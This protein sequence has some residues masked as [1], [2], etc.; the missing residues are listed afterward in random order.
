MSSKAA[1]KNNMLAFAHMLAEDSC[2]LPMAIFR[3][4][5]DWGI[6]DRELAPLVRIAAPAFRQG[7]VTLRQ[8]AEEFHCPQDKALEI[9]QYFV[10]R[11]LLEYD[12]QKDGYT[13]DKLIGMI[14]E[15]WL[16]CR[17]ISQVEAK[18]TAATGVS[19]Y[20]VVTEKENL[21]QLGR[22]YRCFERDFGR[23]LRYTESD[24]LR[25]WLDDEK[26]PPE[27][28][29]E[30]L[31]RASLQNK[32]SFAYIGSILD[33]WRREGLLSLEDVLANDVKPVSERQS[34]GKKAAAKKKQKQDSKFK[35]IV[36]DL[37]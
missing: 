32:C 20:D 21:R 24:R 2:S 18:K 31:R 35:D 33:R 22:L 8:V 15:K 26:W 19:P 25:T 23:N 11:Q 27:L 29:E 28:I 9:V 3:D 13:C 37:L 16:T 34:A 10:D 7:G 17:R 12:A 14:C 5:R 1:E 6:G 36:D 4:Y 30:A